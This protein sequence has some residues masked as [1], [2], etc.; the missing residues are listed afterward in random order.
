M[1]AII[2]L[3]VLGLFDIGLLS[4]SIDAT[5]AKFPLLLFTILLM[6]LLSALDL[7]S[8]PMLFIF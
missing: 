7:F 6:R 5:H 3:L 1:L 4:I 2:V 8:L